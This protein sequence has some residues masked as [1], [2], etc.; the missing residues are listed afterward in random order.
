M[1]QSFIAWETQPE[2]RDQKK[3]STLIF[4]ESILW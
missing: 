4:E 3:H 1:K 2:L